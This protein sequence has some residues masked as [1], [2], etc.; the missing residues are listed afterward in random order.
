MPLLTGAQGATYRLISD[1]LSPSA[2][3]V[4][5]RIDGQ[6]IPECGSLA[7][8][9]T[10][11]EGAGLKLDHDIT[12]LVVAAQDV[13]IEARACNQLGQC[14]DWSAPQVFELSKPATPKGLRIDITV[15]VSVSSP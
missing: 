9:C 1:E 15:N 5:I 2:A 11:P 6:E 3:F 8:H 14:S 13:T 7:N 12:H 10:S 4:G